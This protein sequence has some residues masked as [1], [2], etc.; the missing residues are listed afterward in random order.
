MEKKCKVREK[1]KILFFLKKN[2][3][4]NKFPVESENFFHRIRKFRQLG[5]L[6]GCQKI[7]AT[8][9]VIFYRRE[10]KII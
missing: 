3:R 8:S 10:K 2:K 5:Q 4:K 6:F 7:L 9:I 1:Q